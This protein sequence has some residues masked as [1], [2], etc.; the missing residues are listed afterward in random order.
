VIVSFALL[1]SVIVLLP[2]IA[3]TSLRAAAVVDRPV[4]YVLGGRDSASRQG[5][6][7]SPGRP[8]GYDAHITAQSDPARYVGLIEGGGATSLRDDVTWAFVEPSPGRFNWS[9]PDE[10]VAE[11]A[12][13]HLHALLIVD[14]SP[15]WASG[16]SASNPLWYWL[17][18][19][20]PDAYGV[21]AAAIAARYGPG[22]AFWK[23]NPR[24]PRYLPAGLE[25]W[26]EENSSMFWGGLPPNPR[27]YAAMVTAAYPQI[28]RADSS[29]TVVT[30]GLAPG[31]A[32]DDVTCSG[33]GGSG[34]NAQAWNGLNYLQALYADGIRGHFDAV[35]WHP[36]NYWK[37]A[38]A[39][40]MLAYDR[41][42]A[43]SQ[44]ASTP[45]SV[46]SL[47]SAHGDAAKR[48]W[49]TETGAPTCIAAATYRCVGPAQQADL[50]SAEAR[51]WQ[52]LSWA[53]GFYWYD[54][55]DSNSASQEDDAHFGA[56][57]SDDSSKPAY[58]TLRQ[59][60]TA[61]PRQKD[62]VTWRARWHTQLSIPASAGRS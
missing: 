22:G 60:W 15:L 45:V 39:A 11:A 28:K 30:G 8:V 7:A 43:W 35:G 17:P 21:F 53:G 25:L 4:S 1:A 40:Q 50:A 24:L 49:I 19:R 56:V 3:R 34:H 37:G 54:I 62:S 41:C 32:Y 26:N 2:G 46:R 12:R 33:S 44:M 29:M 23:E 47:M 27:L 58:Q 38:T 61:A 59:A 10:I 16:G 31:G 42:S 9:A 6:V 57:T 20:S 51:L 52:T 5:F 13:H 48:I 14:S 36:Y 18:P 55:R